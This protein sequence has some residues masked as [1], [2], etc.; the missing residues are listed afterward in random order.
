MRWH[1]GND[2]WATTL[3]IPV[4]PDKTA[5]TPPPVQYVLDQFADVFQ[6]CKDL[7]PSRIHDHDVHLLPGA[8]PINMRPCRYS[9][10]LKDEIERQMAEMLSTGTIIPIMSP[11][12]SHVLLVNKKDGTWRFCIDYR[13]LNSITIKSKFPMP[14][15]DELAGT[16]WFSKLDLSAGYHHIRKLS[17]RNIR[18]HLKHVATIGLESCPLD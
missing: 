12:A 17:A 8:T 7:P 5:S 6:E 1:T 16:K 10:L 3:V 18:Q 4:P 9:P 13:K 2:I 15:V 14:C 11:F